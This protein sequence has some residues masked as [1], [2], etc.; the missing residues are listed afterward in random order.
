MIRFKRLFKSF[1]YAFRGLVKTFREEQ[2]L[3]I[4][5]FVAFLAILLGWYLEI[6]KIEWCVIILAIGM[7]LLAEII[8]TAVEFVTDVLKPRIDDY[9]KVIKDIMAAAVMTSS[10]IAVIVG[11]IIFV[12]YLFKIWQ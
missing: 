6:N 10:I 2:N 5:I 3:R 4:Q 8:N 12:P 11:L 9:V 1:N 7:V